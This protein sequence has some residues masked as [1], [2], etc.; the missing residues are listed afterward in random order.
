MFSGAAKR[1]IGMMVS[2]FFVTGC[3]TNMDYYIVGSGTET[4][5]ETVIETVYEEIEVPVYIDT[6]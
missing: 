3:T 1:I 6:S 4:I 5:V 2:I